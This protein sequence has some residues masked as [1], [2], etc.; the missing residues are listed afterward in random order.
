[1]CIFEAIFRH[2]QTPGTYIVAGRVGSD[3]RRAN[4]AH[5]T[6]PRQDSV[7][8]LQIKVL[9]TFQAVPSSIGSGT[10]SLVDYFLAVPSS[11]GGGTFYPVLKRTIS[12]SRSREAFVL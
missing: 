5:T 11:I 6:Q 2:S 9:E 3:R 4:I 10:F 8:G 7:L 1:M 12:T